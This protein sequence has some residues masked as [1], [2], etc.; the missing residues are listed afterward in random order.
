LQELSGLLL[1]E[2]DR[3]STGHKEANW[4]SL[5]WQ[6]ALR[7]MTETNHILFG[8]PEK[9]SN[10]EQQLSLLQIDAL[11]NLKGRISVYPSGA[12]W[13]T[14][15]QVDMLLSVARLAESSLDGD[16]LNENQ[17][18]SLVQHSADVLSFAN[19]YL[20]P[21]KLT[22]KLAQSVKRAALMHDIGKADPR[23]Q[24]RLRGKPISTIFMFSELLAKSG[25][26]TPQ[27]KPN[28]L[29]TGFRH[30]TVSVGLLNQ[31][32]W[33]EAKED[34]GIIKY[35]V[36]AHHG[37]GRP[38]LPCVVDESSPV[39]D[40]RTM[41]GFIVESAQRLEWPPEHRVEA[42]QSERFWKMNRRFGWWGVTWLEALVRLADWNASAVPNQANSQELEWPKSGTGR[43]VRMQKEVSRFELIGI[44][45]SNPLGY[46]AALGCLRIL[47]TRV[48]DYCW[49]LHWEKLRGA[50]RPVVMAEGPTSI[51]KDRFLI[52]LEGALSALPEEHPALRLSENEGR[53]GNKTLFSQ[54]SESASKTER[55]DAD[56]LT[57]NG[58]D[59][60]SG[61]AISQL[62]TSRRDYHSIN[63]RGLLQETTR[64]HLDRSLFSIWDYADALAGV[65]LHLEPRED[66]R[67]AY[68]WHQ[69]SG[70]PTRGVSGGM[71]GANRL[72][73]EAWP[74]FQ[75]LPEGAKLKTVGFHGI[76]ASD[77]KLRWCIWDGSCNL[78]TIQ[79]LLNASFIH[80]RSSSNISLYHMGITNLFHCSR[81]LVGKTPNLTPAEAVQSVHL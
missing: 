46:L 39:V 36:A 64:E 70:D 62:Q 65:S 23:F 25:I 12:I 29:P 1:R 20:E 27:L 76:R 60:L 67:H 9:A 68:Q 44:D 3:E 72:A 6:A 41:G 56:W 35:L 71:I 22:D 11:Q 51:D 54:A 78:N 66:R 4:S 37:Y 57:C 21:I 31:Y 81:I 59:L 50:W 42:G 48:V 18:L 5:Y 19:K 10:L 40:L 77:T 49:R 58:S 33:D 2:Y 8:E 38:F 73:L 14:E 61:E 69:P 45:G 55:E 24:A 16:D 32:E 75:S 52:L 30:E 7:G 80:E 28:P 34:L 43:I 47:A 74:L 15:R 17:S 26:D 13:I 79:S 53:L 63:I